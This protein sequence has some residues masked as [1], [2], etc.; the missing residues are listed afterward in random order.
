MG[1]IIILIFLNRTKTKNYLY[2]IFNVII[3]STKLIF[4]YSWI[5]IF[6]CIIFSVFQGF[7]PIISLLIMQKMINAIQMKN[8]GQDIFLKLIFIYI[9]LEMIDLMAVEIYNLYSTTFM[10]RFTRHIEILMLEKA[11]RLTTKDFEN[12]E[13]YDLINR[14]QSQNGATVIDYFNSWILIFQQAITIFSSIIIIISYQYWIVILIIIAP[15]IQF[16]YSQ[17]LGHEQYEISMKRTSEERKCWYINF[18]MLLGNSIKETILY[19][20]GNLFINQYGKLKEKFILQD[21]K[22]MKKT[23]EMNFIIIIIGQLFTGV[24]Y[25]HILLNGFWQKIY[26]GDVTTYITCITTIK[27]GIEVILSM[28]STIYSKSLYMELLFRFFDIP[29]KT[30]LNKTKLKIDNIEKIELKHLYYKFTEDS[31]YVLKDIN[32]ELKKNSPIALVGRN[33]SGKSTLIKIILGIYDDYEGDILIN[34][35]NLHNI[36]KENYYNKISCVFQDYTK[37]EASV[38]ENVGYGNLDQINNEDLIKESLIKSGLDINQLG[39]NK[40]NTILGYWFGENQLSEGQWQKIAI[41]RAMMKDADFYILDEPDAALDGIAENDMLLTYK[42]MFENKFGI[43]VSHKTHHLN[44][45][46]ENIIV[47]NNGQIAECG[48][49]EELIE[50]EGIYHQ[51]YSSQIISK[52]ETN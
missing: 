32:L 33:G 9:V 49:H 20:L 40:L 29:E 43:F 51:L 37:Y 34:G 3:N 1:V 41:S 39:S 25:F 16:Y 7:F 19:G 30:E 13:I 28:M 38:K 46:C 44:L 35:I 4:N 23:F 48:N 6:L 47:L 21:Y 14:A 31:G 24:I 26:M 11:N 36:E 42:K 17:K 15:V 50:K 22:I 5:Y 52:L 27:N 8:I 10:K 18:L 45:L 2:Q 12:K